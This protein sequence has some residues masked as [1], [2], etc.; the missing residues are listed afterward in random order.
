MKQL[1]KP[2]FHANK[3]KSHCAQACIKSIFSITNPDEEFSWKKLEELTDYIEGHGAWAYKELLTLS[4][5][6]LEVEYITNFNIQ[7]FINEGFSYIEDEFGKEVAD[8]ERTQPH[9]YNK[10]KQ[11]MQ[12][13]LDKGLVKQREGRVE[14]I[15][16]YIDDG[17][18]VMLL[19]NSKALN[20][21][22]GYTGH[23][24]LVY[25]YDNDELLMH[26]PGPNDK[27]ETEGRKVNW[28]LLD[29]A[30]GNAKEMVAVRKNIPE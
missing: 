23:R 6:G 1:N 20:N 7:R 8:Y 26:D 13:S 10:V 16:S 2:V 12:Q 24:V 27:N 28:E 17:W 21:K 15:K 25:G 30:W 5:Y 19:L 29:K 11:Q 9:D 22:E 14:D 18:Y 4:E 3:D